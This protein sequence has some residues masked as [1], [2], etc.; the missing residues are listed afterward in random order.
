MATKKKANPPP[1]IA[2]MSFSNYWRVRT[3]SGS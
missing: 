1:S 3:K 2:A